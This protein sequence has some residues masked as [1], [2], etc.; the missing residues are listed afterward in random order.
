M[1][2]SI[3]LQIICCHVLEMKKKYSET[4]TE[5]LLWKEHHRSEEDALPVHM[6]VEQWKNETYH[7]GQTRRK[8]YQIC[9][10]HNAQLHEDTNDDARVNEN[11]LNMQRKYMKEDIASCRSHLDYGP[12]TESQHKYYICCKR[13]HSVR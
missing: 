1:V 5:C 11:G 13:T 8:L 9:E 4:E 6:V 12:F 3:P 2:L 10:R 7:S